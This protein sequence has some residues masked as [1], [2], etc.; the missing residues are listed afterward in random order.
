MCFFAE[1]TSL[2]SWDAL[3]ALAT[4]FTAVI[5]L[6]TIKS[7]NKDSEATREQQKIRFQS[8]VMS[9]CMQEYFKIRRDAS[10]DLVSRPTEAQDRYSERV[11][12]LHFEQYHLFRQKAIPQ[13]VYSI[14]IKSLKKEVGNPQKHYPALRID[15]YVKRD[16][17]ED[18]N[19]FVSKVLAAATDQD[20]ENL[21]NTEAALPS[22]E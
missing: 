8:T 2:F 9:A 6:W 21:V 1:T 13:H 22:Y 19:V 4:F 12:G 14:W 5:A 15:E 10:D 16:N 20:V 7:A 11:Y 3:T 17:E 18:F